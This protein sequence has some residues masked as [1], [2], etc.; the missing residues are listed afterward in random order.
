RTAHVKSFCDG[1]ELNALLVE[2]GDDVGR[3]RAE[4]SIHLRHDYEGFALV[5]G[6]EEFESCGTTGEW[7]AATDSRIREHFGEMELLHSAV[8]GDPL[9]LD[10]EAEATIGLFFARNSN[11]GDRVVHGA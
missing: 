7:L 3:D 4:Q 11:V 5:R 9:A 6:D 1:D 2:V 10:F 8:G